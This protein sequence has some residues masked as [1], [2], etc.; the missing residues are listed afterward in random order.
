MLQTQVFSLSIYFY[1]IYFYDRIPYVSLYLVMYLFCRFDTHEAAG[2]T[3]VVGVVAWLV[4][5]GF[6]RV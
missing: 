4:I 6:V 3:A 2:C 1:Y 5:S